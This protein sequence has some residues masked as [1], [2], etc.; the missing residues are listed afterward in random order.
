MS[1][2]FA[3]S[4]VAVRP[5]FGRSPNIRRTST[6]VQLKLS[7]FDR[8]DRRPFGID[9]GPRAHFDRPLKR[10]ATSSDL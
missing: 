6:K 3:G 1:N 2:K 7:D 10:P 4:L 5:I 8:E 9:F